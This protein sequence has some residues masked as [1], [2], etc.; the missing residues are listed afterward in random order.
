MEMEIKQPG[1]FYIH[2]HNLQLSNCVGTEGFSASILA[3]ESFL[4]GFGEE[5]IFWSLANHKQAHLL[6]KEI[7][8]TRCSFIVWSLDR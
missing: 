7:V 8:F 3:P 1:W 4:A 6:W 2:K 5:H